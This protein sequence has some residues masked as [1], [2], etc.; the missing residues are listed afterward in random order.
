MFKWF[1][2]ATLP[3][4]IGC[5]FTN[6]YLAVKFGQL[7]KANDEKYLILATGVI[8]LPCCYLFHLMY[9]FDPVD[10]G[11]VIHEQALGLSSKMTSQEGS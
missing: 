9:N 10:I 5:W 4:L 1:S 2:R 8:L 3:L 11:L 7:F 6:E